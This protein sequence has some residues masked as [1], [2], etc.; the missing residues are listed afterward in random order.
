MPISPDDF[1]LNEAFE[2]VPSSNPSAGPKTRVPPTSGAPGN[3][4]PPAGAP[5][6]LQPV[7]PAPMGASRVWGVALLVLLLG[8][9]LF[10]G[11]R[12]QAVIETDAQ[13]DA[14]S[15]SG[16]PVLSPEAV[17]LAENAREAQ[18]RRARMEAE[19]A[20]R[21][22]RE[23][24][25]KEAAAAAEREQVLQPD[26]ERR[27]AVNQHDG[28]TYAWI[29]PGTFQM[30]CSEGDT[31][32]A[33]D[34][35]PRHSVTIN[36]GFRI[37][38]TEVTK[39]AYRRVMG[40]LPQPEE[41]GFPPAE[42]QATFDRLTG[43]TSDSSREDD[44]FPVEYVRWNDAQKYCEAIGMRLPTEAEW[45]Y[46]A[47]GGTTGPRYADL[48]SIAWYDRNHRDGDIKVHPVGL[49]QANAYGLFDILGNAREWIGGDKG[50]DYYSV[51]GG[52]WFSNARSVRVSDRDYDSVV[53]RG[54]PINF[55]C[56]RPFPGVQ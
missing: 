34:E 27:L 35:K 17:R 56:V 32:C 33:D 31:E 40:R 43:H 36:S 3:A 48:D 55:R 52:A 44:Q 8:W 18:E 24:L 30:G 9:V 41:F 5:A 50:A 6:G 14:T 38:T 26:G 22:E 2:D 10:R 20:E 23:R 19:A 7:K 11:V 4:A 25:A 47:R 16:D 28:L 39:K 21:L 12:P 42:L 54:G 46:A 1:D 37:G 53:P 49:K 29:P 45:E 51:R 15:Q 13:A